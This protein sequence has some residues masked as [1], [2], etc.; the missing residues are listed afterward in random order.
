M[1][2]TILTVR[3]CGGIIILLTY[4]LQFFAPNILNATLCLCGLEIS[5]L[6]QSSS[7]RD[8]PRSD[9]HARLTGIGGEDLV[10]NAC[11][12]ARHTRWGARATSPKNVTWHARSCCSAGQSRS[13]WS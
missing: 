7:G 13:R 10:V 11:N 12:A 8:R 1:A 6:T 4:R 3:C 2:F 5:R 9:K